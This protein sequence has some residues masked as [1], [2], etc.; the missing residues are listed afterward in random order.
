MQLGEGTILPSSTVTANIV[1]LVKFIA[2]KQFRLTEKKEY[3]QT[4]GQRATGERQRPLISSH[5]T[6][7]YGPHPYHVVLRMPLR[8]L[9]MLDSCAAAVI[10]AATMYHL[11]VPLQWWI[12]LGGILADEVPTQEDEWED[13]AVGSREGFWVGGSRFGSC[14]RPLE[15]LYLPGLGL[16]APRRRRLLQYLTHTGLGKYLL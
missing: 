2:H 5:T 4:E 14:D 12:H 1:M 6:G 3:L 13:G 11:S 8:V 7:N 9:H 16:A 15:S 10:A